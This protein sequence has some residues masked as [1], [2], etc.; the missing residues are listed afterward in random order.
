MTDLSAIQDDPLVRSI[1]DMSET[2]DDVEVAS[3]RGMVSNVVQALAPSGELPASEKE[4]HHFRRATAILAAIQRHPDM[5]ANGVTYRGRPEFMTDELL[6]ALREEAG[7]LRRTRALQ[8]NGHLIVVGGESAD[9]FALGDDLRSLVERTS[10]SVEPTGVASYLYYDV[11][12]S[13]LAAHVDTDIFS[14]NVNL[15]LAHDN[16]MS[17]PSH[18]YV[19]HNDGRTREAIDHQPGEMVITYGDSIVHGR[20]PVADDETVTLLTVGFQ[21]ERWFVP[22][23]R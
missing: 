15:K 3:L 8:Q 16:P 9:R 10:G 23:E 1:L 11:P 14:I 22:G 18:L 4:R 20:T 21:P 6:T 7:E 5:P 19:F 2:M 13:H 12:G 17:P